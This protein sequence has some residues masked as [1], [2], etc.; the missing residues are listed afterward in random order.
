MGV[1]LLVI[2]AV[3]VMSGV[4]GAS[5]HIANPFSMVVAIVAIAIFGGII[6]EAMKNRKQRSKADQIEMVEIKQQMTR[7]EADIAD[8]K[9]QIA[10]ILIRQV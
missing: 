10:D 4:F 8:I 1:V 3:V 2:A 7:M 6:S 5:M 9:E